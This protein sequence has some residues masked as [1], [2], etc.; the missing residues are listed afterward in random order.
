ML[1]LPAVDIRGGRCVRLIQ[2]ARERERVYDSDPVAAALRW[3]A[4]G[5]SWIHVVDLDGAFAGQRVNAEVITRLIAAVRVPVQVGGG[6][7][8]LSM[9]ERL[10][11]AGAGRVILGTL[12][13]TSAGLLAEACGLFGDR[14]AVAIDARD[15]NVV[16][17]GWLT[18]TGEPA[19]AAAARVVRAG[20]RRIIYTDTG[21]DGT[22][23]GPNLS[24]FEQVLRAV[25]VPVIVSGGVSSVQDVRRLRAL[26]PAGLEGV[27][28]GR[29]L[30]E[31]KVR[32]EDL[33]AVSSR[34]PPP[35]P[36]IPA[37]GTP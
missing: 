20:A 10:L 27:I 14:L 11:D 37:R 8:D 6:V 28:V 34:L 36:D 18:G 13:A 33:L 23:E 29:A 5:A 25:D 31:G 1:V 7:R 19:L 35:Q 4:A 30:Y 21:R 17:D 26:E 15:G 9:I 12:A 32:L 3:E 16:V 24:A 22:L 2:G